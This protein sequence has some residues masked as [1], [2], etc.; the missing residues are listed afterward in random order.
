M[1]LRT[2]FVPIPKC[3]QRTKYLKLPG[4]KKILIKTPWKIP[5]GHG[6]RETN[7]EVMS[8]LHNPLSAG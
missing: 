8:T 2:H 3:R 1:T 5:R 6:K 4:K 7:P